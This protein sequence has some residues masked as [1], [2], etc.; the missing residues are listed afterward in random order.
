MRNP[1][2]SEWIEALSYSPTQEELDDFLNKLEAKKKELIK[3]LP[4]ID[5]AAAYGTT[6]SN[7]VIPAHDIVVL[8]LLSAYFRDSL[9]AKK[10]QT[11]LAMDES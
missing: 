7:P 6:G 10:L 9:I 11:N 1:I 3:L 8:T 5:H 2:N 4:L